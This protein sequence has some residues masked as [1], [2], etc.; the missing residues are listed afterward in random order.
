MHT[1]MSNKKLICSKVIPKHHFWAPKACAQKWS[2]YK[3]LG[4]KKG[5]GYT[6][7]GDKEWT[8]QMDLGE[9]ITGNFQFTPFFSPFP[10]PKTFSTMVFVMSKYNFRTYEFV[11]R[12]GR[13]PLNNITNVILP[14][15][16]SLCLAGMKIFIR[17]LSYNIQRNIIMFRFEMKF[18]IFGITNTEIKEDN[19]HIG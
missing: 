16:F 10:F 9:T 11:V 2:S 7:M 13:I 4:D 1:S 14:F 15:T 5:S 19:L 17:Q 18:R 12:H 6:V 3:D 8:G